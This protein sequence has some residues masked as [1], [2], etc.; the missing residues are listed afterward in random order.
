MAANPSIRIF[1]SLTGEFIDRPMTAAEK[2]EYNALIAEREAELA[3]R[4]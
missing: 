1:D 2:A 4:A 3:A